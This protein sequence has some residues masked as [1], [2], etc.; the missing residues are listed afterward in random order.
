MLTT[1]LLLLTVAWTQTAAQQDTAS[2]HA[3]TSVS[4]AAKRTVALEEFVR[5]YPDSRFQGK[6]NDALFELYLDQN[7]TPAALRAAGRSIATVAPENR[8]GPYNRFAYALASR[9]VGLDTALAYAERA[10]LQATQMSSRSLPAIQDT[11]AYVLF[12]LGRSAEAETLQR[13]ALTGNEDDAEYVSHLALYEHA[14]GKLQDALHTLARS[15]YLGA[16]ESFRDAFL[17]WIVEAG[18][19][20]AA[21]QEAK[22]SIVMKTIHAFTDTLRGS[23]Q[24]AALS[25]ASGL[26]AELDVDLPRAR[27]W[28]EAAAGSLHPGSSVDDQV[29]FTRNL[30]VVRAAQGD[31]REALAH[32]VS[33]KDIVD[34]Y[35]TRFWK[36]LAATCTMTGDTTGAIEAYMQG[37]LVGNNPPL[38]EALEAV[39][40]E[41]HGSASGIDRALD[42]L[43]AAAARVL[44]GVYGKPET[45]SGKVMLAE[46]FTGAECGPCAGSDLAFD[47]LAEYYPRTA[48]AILEYHVH[49]P[50]PDPM[51]TNASWDRY[52]WYAGEGTPTAVFEG[53]ESIIGGGPRVTATNRFHVYRHAI[54]K[55]ETVEPGTTLSLAVQGTGDTLRL[56]LTVT[57]AGMR[58]DTGKPVLHLALVE[59]SVAYT[60]TNGIPVHAFVVRWLVDGAAGIPLS[61]N[62]GGETVRRLISLAEVQRS[63][64]EYLD[65]PLTQPSWPKSRKTFSGWKARPEH[66]DRTNLAV[67]AWVQDMHT[68]EVLQS[69]YRNVVPPREPR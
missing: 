8:S 52:L 24:V 2:Y 21:R 64:T 41:H 17:A 33:I 54:G 13:H 58:Q 50:G 9:K 49:I 36:L 48:L 59:R 43:R 29:T 5:A 66:L 65:S 16:E 38:R 42:S 4:D 60:G 19:N 39:Y 3:A 14:N 26:M 12:Q 32:L 35:D 45:P 27:S 57:P 68:K 15:L 53:R 44:P 28:A 20:D 55:S 1:L 10:E 30:A 22:T 11:R 56:D 51:T 67:V 7:N 62:P 6:A 40:T 31:R 18:E 34:P 46:L 63:I 69:A 37:L 25:N 47:A 23:A 61:W